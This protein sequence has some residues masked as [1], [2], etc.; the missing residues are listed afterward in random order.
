MAPA[1]TTYGN[2]VAVAPNTKNTQL[3]ATNLVRTRNG[4]ALFRGTAMGSTSMT[5][6][7]ANV[8][9]IGFSNAPTAQLLGWRR[10]RQLDHDQRAALDLRRYQRRRE[11]A[12]AS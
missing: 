6:P 5:V 8:A 2:I 10:R 9:N 7:T 1:A 4:V 11:T 3:I 12:P